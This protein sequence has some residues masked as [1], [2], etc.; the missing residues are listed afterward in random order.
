MDPIRAIVPL[1]VAIRAAAD[2][3]LALLV[4]EPEPAPTEKA[5]TAPAEQPGECQHPNRM[6][7]PTG[8]RPDAWICKLCDHIHEGEPNA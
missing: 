4:G 1:L 7:I 5:P 2:A 8:G 3:A 6:P